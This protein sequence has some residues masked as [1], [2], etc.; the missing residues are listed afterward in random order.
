[1]RLRSVS[2]GAKLRHDGLHRARWART[3]LARLGVRDCESDD[4]LRVLAI[5]P[6]NRLGEDVYV[7]LTAFRT[8]DD[9]HHKMRLVNQVLSSSRARAMPRKRLRRI[10]RSASRAAMGADISHCCSMSSARLRAYTG[11]RT[12]SSALIDKVAIEIDWSPIPY[13]RIS[14]SSWAHA[15]HV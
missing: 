9:R 14:V 5:N 4:R 1:M 12:A 3:Q 8:S 13:G 10:I 11:S 15:P 6:I 7:S 2:V